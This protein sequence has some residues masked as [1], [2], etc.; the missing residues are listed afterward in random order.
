M[1]REIKEDDY[2]FIPES[3]LTDPPDGIIEHLKDKWWAVHPE[4]GLMFYNRKG[5]GGRRV[6]LYGSPQCNLNKT[7]SEYVARGYPFEVEIKFIPS[8][9]I[10]VDM[11]EYVM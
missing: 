2:L 11:S 6:R 1:P 5:K 9:F 4:K 7:I 8:V 3:E 10:R